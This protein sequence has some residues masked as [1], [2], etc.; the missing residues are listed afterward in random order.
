[1][2]ILIVMPF[3]ALA[4]AIMVVAI[5]RSIRRVQDFRSAPG[6]MATRG[7]E[8]RTPADDFHDRV[9]LPL[10]GR[11]ADAVREKA[12]RPLSEK[13]RRIV[14][15]ARSELALNVAIQEIQ[16]ARK[17]EEVAALLAS[18][19]TGLDRPDPTGWCE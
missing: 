14:W 1:M 5:M 10:C 17:G 2:L 12:N 11:V 7:I 6:S 9:W 4:L 19:P 8:R 13:E 16:S 18:L 15:R 3:A